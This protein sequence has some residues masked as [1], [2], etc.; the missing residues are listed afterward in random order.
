MARKRQTRTAV[1]AVLDGL[2]PEPA[3][4]DYRRQHDPVELLPQPIADVRG[5][6]GQPHRAHTLYDRLRARGA[7]ETMALA[8][9]RFNEVYRLAALDPLQAAN[10]E[11]EVRY[12]GAGFGQIVEW[13]RRRRDGAIDACGGQSSPAGLCAWFVLGEEHSLR[14]WAQREGWNGRS[15]SEHAAKGVLLGT[16]GVLEGFFAS[17]KKGS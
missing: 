3:Q 14:E 13:A 12:Q 16:L 8:A 17:G 2:P 10:Y 9:V 11:R 1:V 7:T 4:I 15:M 6:Y 5:D